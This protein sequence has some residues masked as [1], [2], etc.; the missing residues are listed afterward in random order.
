MWPMPRADISR[1]RYFVV[2]SARS[3]VSGSPISLLSEPSGAIVGPMRST[4]W[5]VR[6]LVEVLPD[7]PVMPTTVAPGSRSRTARASRP[8]ATVTAATTR[9]RAARAGGGVVVTVHA[10]AG[11]RGEQRSW[12]RLPR[13]DHDGTGHDGV[14]QV[15]HHEGATGDRGDLRD[16]QRDHGVP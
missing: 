7:E 15:I 6:S 5:A 10:L 8:R 2:S 1:T 16:G 9:T 12:H 11:Q 13:V 14:G 4:T 3:T